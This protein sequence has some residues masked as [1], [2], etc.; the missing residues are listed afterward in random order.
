MYRTVLN[1]LLFTG[2]YEIGNIYSLHEPTSIGYLRSKCTSE[3]DVPEYKY[4]ALF[5][6]YSIC[7]EHGQSTVSMWRVILVMVQW[8]SVS[9]K[10]DQ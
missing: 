7:F 9:I 4:P 3:I 1:G 8:F 6:G 2:V 10:M 5:T